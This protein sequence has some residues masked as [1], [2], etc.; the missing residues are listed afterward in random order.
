[1]LWKIQW[2]IDMLPVWMQ[3][4]YER[5]L[6]QHT[7]W[8]KDNGALLRGYAAGQDVAAGG[9]ATVFTCD[10][11]GAKDFIAA[12]KDESV[13]EALHDVTGCIRM[14]SAR[15]ADSGVFHEACE[16]PDTRK[17]G[18]YLVLDWKDHPVHGK[19]SYVVQN[20]NPVAREAGRSGSSRE[21]PCGQSGPAREAGS[22]GLQ[23]GRRGPLARGTTC[24][25]SGRRQPPG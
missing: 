2:A 16:N 25:V 11:F 1:M 14:V 10:E 4:K 7:F 15:Y 12:G 24:G 9:R 6:A 17:N 13:M 19:N 23:V 20:G 21:V 5:N 22:E 8:N 18:V 3:P